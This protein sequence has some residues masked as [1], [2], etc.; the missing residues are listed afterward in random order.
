MTAMLDLL[1]RVAARIGVTR[2]AGGRGKSRMSEIR[3][4]ARLQRMLEETQKFFA[5]QHKLMAKTARLNPRRLG[6]TI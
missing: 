1:V 2:R 3:E 6:A 4:R 5:Q